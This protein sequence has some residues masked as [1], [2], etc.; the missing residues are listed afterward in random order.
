MPLAI[1]HNMGVVVK[2]PLAN[3][4]W[5]HDAPPEEEYHVPYW[6]RFQ[7]L[8]YPLQSLPL[9]EAVAIAMRFTASIPGVSTMIVGTTKPGRWSDNAAIIAQGNLP[10]EEFYILRNHWNEVKGDDWVGLQ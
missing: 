3:V 4:A 9:N 10:A 8:Q 2:R 7:K 1:K 5:R 6:E